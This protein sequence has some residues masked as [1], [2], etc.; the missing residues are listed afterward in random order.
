MKRPFLIAILCCALPLFIVLVVLRSTG[1]RSVAPPGDASSAPS[2]ATVG[3]RVGRLA[4]AFQLTDLD[5][6]RV[7]NQGLAGKPAI[8]WFTASYCVPC[9]LGAKEVR[10][11]DDDLG[12]GAF[13][14]VMVFIDQRESEADLRSW[15]E[16]FANPDWTIAFGDERLVDDYAI[17]LLDTQ[18]LL[19]GQG[20]IRNVANTTV[21]HDGYKTKI[22]ALRP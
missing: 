13:N 14:V 21:G 10:Q 15:Q 6:R 9:Q 4:P 22:E 18:Y 20:V 5:G 12:G 19:D 17:R 3:V 8:L 7:T 1:K 11:L 2:A 16:Q